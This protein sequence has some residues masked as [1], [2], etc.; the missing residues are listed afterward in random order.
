MTLL[1]T[2]KFPLKHYHWQKQLTKLEVKRN[3][4]IKSLF[5]LVTISLHANRKI[6]ITWPYCTSS[7]KPLLNTILLVTCIITCV[8]FRKYIT[9]HMTQNGHCLQILG[10]DDKGNKA[11]D[12]QFITSCQASSSI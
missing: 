9:N 4:Q 10:A 3:H 2:I 5:I 12:I 1:L 11:E 6:A 7:C 8:L